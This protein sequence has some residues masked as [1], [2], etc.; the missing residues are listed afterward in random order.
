MKKVD[1]I[2]WILS[3]L[4]N[5]F[6]IFLIS[7]NPYEHTE[8]TVKIGLISVENN[9]VTSNLKGEKN[10]DSSIKNLEEKN[11]NPI[12]KKN[13]NLVEENKN[14][15]TT[16]I[17]EI[18]EIENTKSTDEVKP[19][20]S[21]ADLKKA[22]S[23]SK[24]KLKNNIEDNSKSFN[25]E[26]ES[27]EDLDRILGTVNGEEGLISGNKNGSL[28]GKIIVKWNS[29]NKKPVFPETAQLDGKNGK[30]VLLLKVDK[31]GNIISYKLEKGSGVPDIDIAI[32]R[33][34]NSWKIKLI[35]KDKEIGGSFYIH[36]NFNL[37]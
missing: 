25:P 16:N 3:I 13:E 28:D 37:K 22:I 8:N 19:K 6:I 1:F 2:S 26:V 35:K 18:N 21:L 27:D 15:K 32:E 7:Y 11:I 5:I 10:I 29:N 14:E 20:K 23:N 31:F 30:V 24:P 12:N 4:I 36:Y 9:N 34:I 17:K 33:V